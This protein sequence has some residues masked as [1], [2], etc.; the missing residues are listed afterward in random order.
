MILIQIARWVP[1]GSQSV[2]IR[3]ADLMA[4]AQVSERTYKRAMAELEDLELVRRGVHDGGLP[5]QRHAR[6]N[7]FWLRM[8]V[9][10]GT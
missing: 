7:R 2:G 4:M 8:R 6:P 3:K 9:P 1:E 10:A 5:S